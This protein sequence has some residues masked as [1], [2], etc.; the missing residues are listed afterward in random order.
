MLPEHKPHKCPVCARG[1]TRNNDLLR[2]RK[3]HWKDEIIGAGPGI[4]AAGAGATASGARGEDD[5]PGEP[6]SA[7]SSVSSGSA[8]LGAAGGADAADRAAGE[9]LSP[10][11]QLRSLH[12]IKG[13]FHCPYKSA[14]IALDMDTYPGKRREL[15]F[16]TSECHQTGVFSRCDTFKNHLKALHFEYP[17]GTKKKDRSSVPGRCKQCGRHFANVGEWLSSHVGKDCGYVY[18]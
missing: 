10:Q 13:T 14:L 1:F 12:Q 15:A 9:S 6:P 3:R 5:A 8:G 17:P 7:S 16:E 4:G 18:H 11:Q 2:H